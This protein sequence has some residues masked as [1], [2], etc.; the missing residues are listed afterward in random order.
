MA[1]S[2]Y[3]ANQLIAL[4]D[5]FGRAALQ[6][7]NA[8]QCDVYDAKAIRFATQATKRAPGNPKTWQTPGFFYQLQ[9]DP[10]AV[11]C[12]K[13]AIS[14]QSPTERRFGYR[15]LSSAYESLGKHAQAERWFLKA[16]KAEPSLA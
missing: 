10:R 14:L 13:K 8:K 16:L 7:R 12:F 6:S 3:N 4:A 11:A 5:Y 9:K 1:K 2:K 15:R